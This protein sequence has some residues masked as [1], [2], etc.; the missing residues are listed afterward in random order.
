MDSITLPR[1]VKLS[2]VR[3][4][5]ARKFF[6][7][8]VDNLFWNRY[9]IYADNSLPEDK[10]FT[11]KGE[12]CQRQKNT[13]LKVLYLFLGINPYTEENPNKVSKSINSEIDNL[14]EE[15][16]LCLSKRYKNERDKQNVRIDNQ[17]FFY[18]VEKLKEYL[19]EAREFLDTIKIFWKHNNKK[20][21][22]P[23]IKNISSD[24]LNKLWDGTN[25]SLANEV[26]SEYHS[27]SNFDSETNLEEKN[28][29]L[30]LLYKPISTFSTIESQSIAFKDLEDKLSD[31]NLFYKNEFKY[32]R[33]P[34]KHNNHK[35]PFYKSLSDGDIWNFI[36]DKNEEIHAKSF[37]KDK[38]LILG[39]NQESKDI[40]MLDYNESWSL[41]IEKTF[42]NV[43]QAQSIDLV[44]NIMKSILLNLFFKTDPSDVWIM[45]YDFMSDDFKNYQN[46][47]HMP[48][49][50]IKNEKDAL[51]SFTY[52]L[53]VIDKKY[54]F[55]NSSN[56]SRS[57]DEI[58]K[59]F[60][61]SEAVNYFVSAE[62]DSRIENTSEEI[63]FKNAYIFI[64][65]I[66]DFED[67]TLLTMISLIA[68][69]G[70]K[71]GI[72]LIIGSQ[73][74]FR[75][76][77][78]NDNEKKRKEKRDLLIK[79][80]QNSEKFL[81]LE[82]VENTEKEFSLSINERFTHML[83]PINISPSD[84]ERVFVRWKKY[85]N[86]GRKLGIIGDK[87]MMQR[88]YDINQVS[89]WLQTKRFQINLTNAMVT[90]V[91]MQHL[92]VD[93][94]RSIANRKLKT[95]SSIKKMIKQKIL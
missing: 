72:N 61:G 17:I 30:S 89:N 93:I 7:I 83:C 31:L 53:D 2:D 36:N 91:N 44:T 43:P 66:G 27:A 87:Y 41:F 95:N 40:F 60:D 80:M 3:P 63:N 13:I 54:E 70:P 56:S 9:Q 38:K 88:G 46:L 42:I 22:D 57:D 62:E 68:K 6:Y 73:T 39:R 45:I 81:K 78:E 12:P 1:S 52:L 75:Y 84:E 82:S 59:V 28:K 55:K 94:F 69:R 58:K 51:K 33:P 49:S 64:K 34:Q 24:V 47:A 77:K 37:E 23:K 26:R 16:N 15:L 79:E 5:I 18:R 21:I 35:A 65:D 14:I 74:Q 8:L 20:Y 48:T 25:E 4:K 10:H 67:N 50:V 92:L 29:K 86:P 19:K 76:K 32:N 85:K 71:V 90:M 11:V